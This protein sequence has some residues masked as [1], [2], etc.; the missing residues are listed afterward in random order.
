MGTGLKSCFSEVEVIVNQR[1]ILGSQMGKWI[2]LAVVVAVLVALL[3]AGVVRAQQADSITIE[4]AENGTDPVATLTAT[5]PEMDEVTWSLQSGTDDGHFDI[6]EDGVLTFAVGTDDTPPDFENPQ[7]GTGNTNTYEVVVVAMDTATPTPNIDMFTVTVEVTNVDEDGEVSWT[8]DHDADDTEDTPKLVQ[9]QVGARLVASVE[10]G[11][12]SGDDK[13]VE[14]AR[15]DVAANPTWR[16][17]RSPSRTS[18]GTMIEGESSATYNVLPADVGMYLRAV[19]YYVITGNVDQESASLTSDYPVLAVRDGDNELKF[20]PVDISR[21]VAEGKKGARV[22]APIRAVGNH[23][24]VNYTLTTAD[25]ADKFVI[26]Q[27]TG[28]ITTNVDLDYDTADADNCRDADFCEVT[29]MATDASGSATAVSAGTNIFMHATVTIKVTDVNEKPDFS[30][31]YE[32]VSVAEGTTVVDANADTDNDPV[33]PTGTSDAVYMAAD[34]E[35]RNLSYQLIGPD[36]S[37]FQLSASQVLSF[38]EKPDYEMPADANRDNVYEVTVRASDSG[39][40]ADRMVM[41]TVTD[42]PEG[43]TI[44]GADSVSY[45]ENGTSPVATFTATDPEGATS[46]TWSVLADDATFATIEG[47]AEADAAD[48]DHFDIS[49]DGVL[50]FDIGGDGAPDNSMSPDFEAPRNVAPGDA[51]PNTYKV[52]VAAADAAAGGQT[53]YHKVT[54][55]VTNVD[56]AGEVTWAVDA[57]G[58]NTPD[59]VMVRQFQVG[60]ILTATVSDGDIS[61][62]IK[63]VDADRTDVA[64]DPTWRWYRGGTLIS[65]TDAEDNTYTVTTADVDSRLRV[66]A[67]YRVGDSVN[68]DSASLTSDYPVLATRSGDNELEFDPAAVSREVAEGEEGAEVGAP[69]TA[70]GNHGAITYTLSGTDSEQFEIDEKTGQITTSEDLNY[71]ADTSNTTNQCNTANSC[72]VTVT[73]TDS[74]GESTSTATTNL[75]ATVAIK[76]TDANEGPE[77]MTGDDSNPMAKTAIGVPE[78]TTVLSTATDIDVDD[79]TYLA[80]DPEGLNVN[81]TLMGPDSAK[82]SIG[83]G[84]VL[85][86]SAGADY[87]DPTDANRDNIYEVTIRAS[88]GTLHIDR[89]VQV[90]V[91]DLNEAPVIMADSLEVSGPESAYYAENSMDAVATYTASGSEAASARWTLEGDDAG[92]L[93]IDGSGASVM[94]RF[95]GSPDFE[96]PADMDGDNTYEVTLRAT[97]GTNT[98]TFDVE[99]MV[100]NE[101]DAGRVTVSPTTAVVGTE[102]TAELAD[103]DGGVTGAAWQWARGDAMGGPFTDIAGAM[104]AEYTTVDDDGGKYVRASVSYDDAE[105]SDKSASSEAVMV[106]MGLGGVVGMYDADNDGMISRPEVLA[107]V[108]DFFDMEITR[109]DVLE[110]IGAYFQ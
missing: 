53:G 70:T 104:S 56:E 110:I 41:V 10:D 81:Y 34:P 38:K 90:R 78:N 21:E 27:K 6:S 50:T 16:W 17:Y 20:A 92:D 40:S 28:Q 95:I 85:S 102:L 77:F 80:P 26:D 93:R 7:G 73:A 22:G 74:T 91:T 57:N 62:T 108:G 58:D 51:N 65:G 49:E 33:T 2:T 89:M 79:V 63:T 9:F 5:D 48:A 13:T 71:E 98:D 54:V 29:V 94:L 44:L 84:G 76:L 43:P 4:Y 105:G 18:M 96:N 24:A 107:A 30:T 99:V 47:V 11:D 55:M 97:E 66:V 52:V 1:T 25:D 31:G 14:A 42:T 103:Q 69:V 101:D 19:A 60:A 88:D 37:K 45:A 39:L 100:T 86:F 83:V 61:G 82:F 75:N 59:T 64:A 109:A 36:G 46:F 68:L 106:N 8:V 72:E 12:I 87:E 15:T 67:T 23:G 3:T 32:T 35:G